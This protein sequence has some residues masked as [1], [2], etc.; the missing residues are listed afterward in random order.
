MFLRG[1]IEELLF[2]IRGDTNNDNLQKKNVHIW[3][4][5]TSRAYL[6]SIGLQ[7]YEEGSLGSTY[8]HQWRHWGAPYETK[9]TDYTG[10]GIDQLAEAVRLI[11]E[12]PTSRRII[13]SGWN[14]SQLKEM[15]L[16]PCH[17]VYQF[18]VNLKTNELNCM[19]T[20]RSA[21]MFLGVPFNIAS[22]ALFTI[23]LAKITGYQPG[24]III[25]FGDTHIYKNHLNQVERQI[26]RHPY[27]FPTIEIDQELNSIRD[28]EQLEYEDFHLKEYQYYPGIKAKMVV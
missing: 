17:M 13:I 27:S 10:K 24:D 21:D 1:I 14:V 7:H 26:K 12:E 15:A 11:R 20:Q 5:N 6:D 23:L 19:M 9:H 4:G 28:I 3:D 8:P 25:N 18:N 2:F 22:T 16:V